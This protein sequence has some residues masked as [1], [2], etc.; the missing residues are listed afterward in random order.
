MLNNNS[1]DCFARTASAIMDSLLERWFCTDPWNTHLSLTHL[2]PSFLSL[3]LF[4]PLFFVFLH[5]D[6]FDPRAAADADRRQAQG[7]FGES[8][9]DWTTSSEERGSLRMEEKLMMVQQR[10]PRGHYRRK[11]IGF[12]SYTLN[13]RPYILSHTFTSTKWMHTEPYCW[14][15]GY[16]TQK[17]QGWRSWILEKFLHSSAE[18][19]ACF[20]LTKA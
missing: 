19:A 13:K 5:P 2:H 10:W 17:Y 15:T 4:P 11:R 7:V 14:C 18:C 1:L 3:S 20:L 6:C 12:Y 16:F 8:N 9:W